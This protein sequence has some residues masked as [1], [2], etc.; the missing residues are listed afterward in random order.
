[1]KGI[2]CPEPLEHKVLDTTLDGGL[3]EKISDCEPVAHPVLD[4]TLDGRPMEGTT[5]PEPL[6]HSVLARSL[7]SGLMEGM[8]SL[9]PLEQSVLNTVLVARPVEGI[10]ETDPS[11]RSALAMQLD[12]EHLNL[13]LPAHPMVDVALDRRPMEGITVP[14][15]VESSGLVM[16]LGKGLTED[17]SGSIP[18]EHS[19]MDVGNNRLDI[20]DEPLFGSDSGWS[21]LEYTDVMRQEALKIRSAGRVPAGSVDRMVVLPA[22]DNL[23]D[24]EMSINDVSSEGLWCWNTDMDIANQYETFNGLPVYYGGDMY[25][26]EDSDLLRIGHFVVRTGSCLLDIRCF[27]SGSPS[28][29]PW[30]RAV[31][32]WWIIV[33]H[34]VWC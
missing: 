34:H 27:Y 30:M 22:E 29:G 9:E 7:D 2:T 8:P 17:L 31:S 12:Y 1:M 19:D 24:E 28:V 25:D 23:C 3:V 6:E 26:S 5:D 18:L 13:E 20:C 15:P 32:R 4:T 21:Y 11:E 10:T 14:L 16:A 33:W